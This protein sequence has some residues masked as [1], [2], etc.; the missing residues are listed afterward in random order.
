LFG[1]STKGVKHKQDVDVILI[2]D[3]K[4]ITIDKVIKLKKE[5]FKYWKKFYDI[6]LDITLL[7]T[8]E[9]IEIK[10]IKRTKAEKII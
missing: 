9:E 5:M 4:Y 1:S 8:E 3:K 2:Y 10:F 6:F 7:S